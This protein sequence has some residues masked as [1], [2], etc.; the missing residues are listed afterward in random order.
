VSWERSAHAPGLASYEI[1]TPAGVHVYLTRV[2]GVTAVVITLLDV[3]GVGQATFHLEL[4]RDM[5]AALV[6][7]LGTIPEEGEQ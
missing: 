4:T 7:A 3:A 1:P 2:S 5:R 6:D